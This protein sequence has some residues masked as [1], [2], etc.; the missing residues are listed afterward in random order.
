MIQICTSKQIYQER[1]TSVYNGDIE[2][3]PDFTIDKLSIEKDVS[4]LENSIQSMGLYGNIISIRIGVNFAMFEYLPSKPLDIT[5][6]QNSANFIASCM[7]VPY[8]NIYAIPSIWIE[9]SRKHPLIPRK[10]RQ[11]FD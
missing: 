10:K 9:F 5:I 7:S 8:I 1:L 3:S 6:I 4:N 11:F 2:I